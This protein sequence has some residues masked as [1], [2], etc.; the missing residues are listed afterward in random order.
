[1]SIDDPVTSQAAV[2][3]HGTEPAGPGSEQASHTMSK[4]TMPCTDKQIECIQEI[5]E[6]VASDLS[7]ITDSELKID[8]VESSL[9][10]SR[11]AGPEKPYISFRLGFRVAGRVEHLSLIHI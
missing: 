3:V 4:T 8:Q 6:R 10:V 1:M 7:M 9:E 2:P 5:L 11:P